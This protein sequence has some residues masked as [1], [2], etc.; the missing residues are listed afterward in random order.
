MMQRAQVVVDEELLRRA[1]R[2]ASHTGSSFSAVVRRALRAWLA[3]R[4]PDTAWLGSLAPQDRKAS[5]RWED[6]EASVAAGM[7][8]ERDVR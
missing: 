3:A 8:G 6:I 1:K 7:A 2:H 4:D 5:H